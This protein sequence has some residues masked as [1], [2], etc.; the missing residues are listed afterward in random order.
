ME[1]G[2]HLRKVRKAHKLLQK[3]LADRAG[4]DRSYISKLERGLG[5]PTWS[6]L[7]KIANAYQLSVPH[8]L[9][10]GSSESFSLNVD[11]A[12]DALKTLK[13]N[14]VKVEI[15]VKPL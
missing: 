15:T 4:L 9:N 8:L 2:T 12:I 6:T 10:Y 5:D 11:A 14:M 7:T 1:I 3:D 13:Y